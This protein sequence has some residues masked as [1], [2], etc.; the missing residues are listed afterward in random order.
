MA[1][2]AER[3]RE[4]IAIG[5]A[6]L[7]GETFDALAERIGYNQA[8][9]KVILEGDPRSGAQLT[10]Q[11]TPNGPRNPLVASKIAFNL[12]DNTTQVEGF[13]HGVLTTGPIMK[14]R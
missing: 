10:Y 14:R 11:T 13:K 4:I 3:A 7:E 5:Q 2:Q 6:Q 9:E 12:R 1:T 8:Q